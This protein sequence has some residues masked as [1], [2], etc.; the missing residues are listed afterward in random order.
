MVDITTTSRT[1]F[2]NGVATHNCYMDSTKAGKHASQDLLRQVFAGLKEAPYQIAFG[3]GEPVAHPDFP[4]FL[5]FTREHGTVP[6]YTTAG[7]IVRDEVIEATNRFCGGVALTYHAFKGPEWFKEMYETWRSLLAPHVQLNVHVIADVDVANNL[8]D[9]ALVGLR[10]LNIVLLAYY[11]DIGRAGYDRLM[12]KGVYQIALPEALAEVDKKGFKIAFS[13]GLLP[14]FLTMKIPTVDPRFATRQEGLFSCY[15]DDKGFVS[16]SSFD[17]AEPPTKHEWGDLDWMEDGER[18]KFKADREAQWQADYD[19]SSIFNRSFQDI[20]N[21]GF[22]W[23]VGRDP[24]NDEC[25]VC[26]HVDSCSAPD[27]THYLQCARAHHN[28]VKA[29]V[30]P[31]RVMPKLKVI[32]NG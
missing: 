3:G 8:L 16:H 23:N 24:G 17:P 22:G 19:N 25:W 7:H 27:E 9:L 2:A 13:E 31:K 15:V 20:W 11:P 5:S 14:Y 26:P 12:P 18:E 10:D 28:S 29:K 6:N 30:R 21:E 32:H 4:W 1:F